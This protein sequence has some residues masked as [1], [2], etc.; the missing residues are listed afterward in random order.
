VSGL[1]RHYYD[2]LPLGIGKPLNKTERR[3]P[4]DSGT[5]RK[6]LAI[7][8]PKKVACWTLVALRLTQADV[9]P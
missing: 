8:G 5:L 4:G 9:Q 6:A 3:Q 1:D 7:P 2:Y